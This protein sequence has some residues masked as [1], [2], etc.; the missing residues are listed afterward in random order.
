[1]LNQC[2]CLLDVTCVIKFTNDRITSEGK[3]VEFKYCSHITVQS[4]SAEHAFYFDEYV[5]G[6]IVTRVTWGGST[7]DF[8]NNSDAKD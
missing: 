7:S 4:T 8:R 1:M 5:T 6:V 3:I 2:V